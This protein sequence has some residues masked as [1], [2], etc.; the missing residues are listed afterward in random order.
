VKEMV[1]ANVRESLREEVDKL[2][3]PKKPGSHNRAFFCL[4]NRRRGGVN[5]PARYL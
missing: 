1:R 3:T 5:H 4:P 2:L